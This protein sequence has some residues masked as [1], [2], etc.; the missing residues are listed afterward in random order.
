MPQTTPHIT[1]KSR[2]ELDVIT[3]FPSISR[4]GPQ[5]VSYAEF[6]EQCLGFKVGYPKRRRF[7]VLDV[8]MLRDLHNRLGARDANV[9]ESDGMVSLSSEARVIET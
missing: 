6:V 9:Y 2:L 4:P 1:I 3:V 8:P 5:S 7:A